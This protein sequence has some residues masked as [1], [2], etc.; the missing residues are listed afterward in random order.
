MIYA[1][2]SNYSDPIL[3]EK[4]KKAYRDFANRHVY[5]FSV[6]LTFR[7]KVDVFQAYY[8]LNKFFLRLQKKAFGKNALKVIRKRRP[9]EVGLE[10]GMED[11]G[12][13]HFHLRLRRPNEIYFREGFDLEKEVRTIWRNLTGAYQTDIK[14]HYFKSNGESFHDYIVKKMGRSYDEYSEYFWDD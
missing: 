6:T 4:T 2:V 14:K 12:G 7:K 5:L 13:I 9:V 11:D 10:V 1:N 3:N 8:Y